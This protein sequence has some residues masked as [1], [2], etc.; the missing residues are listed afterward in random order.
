MT[1]TKVHP[2]GSEI[3]ELH[4]ARTRMGEVKAIAMNSP[5]ETRQKIADRMTEIL[6]EILEGQ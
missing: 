5:Q 2:D 3:P 6:A 4:K 1:E